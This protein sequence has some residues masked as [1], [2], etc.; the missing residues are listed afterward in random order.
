MPVA[1]ESS[2]HACIFDRLRLVHGEFS[3]QLIFVD[4]EVFFTKATLRRNWDEFRARARERVSLED[5]LISHAVFTIPFDKNLTF[6]VYT[7]AVSFISH[8]FTI[9]RDKT[10]LLS[11][12]VLPECDCFHTIVSNLKAFLSALFQGVQKKVTRSQEELRWNALDAFEFLSKWNDSAHLIP[13]SSFYIESLN[14]SLDLRCEFSLW[15]ARK[16]SLIN[17]PFAL[18][19]EMKGKILKI[20]NTFRMRHELQDTFFRALFK[21][22]LCPFLVLEVNRSSLV[23]D[24]LSQLEM[25]SSRDLHKQL[26]VRFVGEDGVDEGGVQKEFFQLIMK[27]VLDV[28]YGMFINIGDPHFSWFPVVTSGED[29]S[30]LEEYTLLGKLFGLAIYNSVN[31]DV[32]F[33]KVLYKKLLKG[34]GSLYDVKNFDSILY[35]S[36]LTIKNCKTEQEFLD[37]GID[38]FSCSLE[39]FGGGK[40]QIPLFTEN[41]GLSFANRSE[42]VDLYADTL[43][44]RSIEPQF[45]AFRTGFDFACAE[46]CISLFKEDELEIL[47]CGEELLDFYSLQSIAIYDNGF[48]SESPVI[49]WF[50]SIVHALPLPD[51]RRL[52]S[53]VTGSDRA[54]IGGLGKTHLTISRNGPDS[55]RLPTAH[56][57]FNILLLNEYET[58]AKLEKL[59]MIAI[60]N[61]NGF[62]LF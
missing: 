44:N 53:F 55:S 38:S 49:V 12:E 6:E 4:G 2:F 40:M 60:H 62:G 15:A 42:Y 29:E 3:S 52:L 8:C 5:F 43:L 21:G 54:P 19:P 11:M 14:D 32:R 13:I 35:N 17:Y 41:L 57:C 50:W 45:N 34:K 1:S 7:M 22:V 56:T 47:V 23:K 37:F 27:E 18:L 59:L 9:L 20:E 58:K 16:R 26:K 61:C 28:K 36:L 25:R 30:I 51:Q 24:T 46:S 39:T 31:L 48:S 10:C 33:P